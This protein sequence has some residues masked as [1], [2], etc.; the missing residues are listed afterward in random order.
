M[1]DLPPNHLN[2]W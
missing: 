1:R 2:G